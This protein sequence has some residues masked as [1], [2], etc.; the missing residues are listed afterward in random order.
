M[1][2]A[3]PDQNFSRTTGTVFW[4]AVVSG[5]RK[6]TWGTSDRIPAFQADRT[7]SGHRPVSSGI[8][9]TGTWSDGG[10]VSLG[11]AGPAADVL[12]PQ[13]TFRRLQNLSS[14]PVS[15]L[16]GTDLQPV[17]VDTCG[18]SEVWADIL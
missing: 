9:R 11:P 12:V 14:E 5:P 3:Q 6:D 10:L 7:G 4:T 2:T 17:T 15:D 13:T 8:I 16:N 1:M 18:G